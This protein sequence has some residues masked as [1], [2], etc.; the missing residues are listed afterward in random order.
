MNDDCVILVK[1]NI[2]GRTRGQYKLKTHSH[3]QNVYIDF[4]NS[5]VRK[6]CV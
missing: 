3:V 6:Q 2:E 1:D 5:N 4:S